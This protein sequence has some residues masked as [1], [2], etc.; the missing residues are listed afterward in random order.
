MANKNIK[1]LVIKVKPSSEPGG[2]EYK[3]DSLTSRMPSFTKDIIS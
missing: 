1:A 3:W 2:V